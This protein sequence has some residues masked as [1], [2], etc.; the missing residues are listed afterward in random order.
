MPMSAEECRAHAEICERM[1]ESL[2][3]DNYG[4]C[5]RQSASEIDGIPISVVSVLARLGLDPRE[6]A[7]RLSS[8]GNRE[9]VEQLA[10]LIAE[11]PGVSAH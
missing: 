1:A 11:V 8:L 6:D 9:A 7:G 5:S 10:R 2:G 3:P 4:S